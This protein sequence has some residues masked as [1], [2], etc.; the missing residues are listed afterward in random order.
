MRNFEQ[1][2]LSRNITE[3]WRRWH[4]SLSSWLRDYL[5]IPLGGNRKG[6]SRTYINLMV[7]MLLGGLWHGASWNFVIWGGLHG[8]YL[9]AHKLSLGSKRISSR[10]DLSNAG[11]I[12]SSIPSILLTN[13]LV[14]LTWLF[15][16]AQDMSI[17]KIFFDKL[18][19]W[20]RSE[21]SYRFLTI[22][23][24]FVMMNLLIDIL[25]YV[26]KDH[27]FLLKINV[28]PVIAGVLVGIIMITFTYMMQSDP[29][30]FVYFQF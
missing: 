17:I 14:L 25:E 8:V 12:I 22:T 11:S 15:F 18:I 2:Y 7:T 20:Q 3:F 24:S 10:I 4:I 29:L 23:I 6:V 27:A 9:A 28:K 5:Y 16:R 21:L 1:P 13:I 30:P 19:Y 26:T